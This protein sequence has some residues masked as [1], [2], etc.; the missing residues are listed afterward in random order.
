MCCSDTWALVQLVNYPEMQGRLRDNESTDWTNTASTN[1]TYPAVETHVFTG[2]SGES[3]FRHWYPPRWHVSC[4][5]RSQ[6][7]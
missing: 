5:D 7:V 2:A 3:D 4:K 6:V 1:L